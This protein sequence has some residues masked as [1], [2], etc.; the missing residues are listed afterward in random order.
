MMQVK[1]VFSQTELLDAEQRC[2]CC[3]DSYLP[4]IE[5]SAL[6]EVVDA[7][8]LALDYYMSIGTQKINPY[9]VEQALEKA[10]A[11]LAPQKE[12]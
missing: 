1:W 11:Q 7:L 2:K 9:T 12:G 6:A 8:R 10:I 4:V 5:L 3:E